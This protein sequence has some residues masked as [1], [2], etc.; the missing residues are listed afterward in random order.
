MKLEDLDLKDKKILAELEMNARISHASLA[1]KVGLSKQVVKYRIEKLEE[2]KIIQGYFAIVDIARLGYFPHI[3]YLKF[4]NLTSGKEKQLIESIN[5]HASVMSVGKNAGNWDLTVVIKARNNSELDSIYREIISGKADK[6]KD[7]LFTT[8]I[9]TTYFTEKVFYSLEGKEANADG[10]KQIK[11]DETDEKI[12]TLLAEDGRLSFIDLSEKL[13][14]S[15]N[16]IK[17]RIKKLEK[18]NVIA[19]YKTKINYELLGFL[20]F[21]VFLHLK[22]M[23]EDFYFKIKAFLKSKGNVESITRCWGYADIDFRVHTRDIFELYSIITEMKD[24]FIEN[25]IDIDSMIIVGWDSINY[26][27][28]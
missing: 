27:P 22:K 24:R 14:M 19:G 9:E 3:I 8:Q 28:K 4:Q 25:I 17:E 21:R 18:E 23:S 16:G 2:E 7:K 11:I 1:K 15:P 26:Y 5:K 12:I 10:R 6:I 20:H 13:K